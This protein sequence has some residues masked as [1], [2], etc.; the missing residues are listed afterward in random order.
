MKNF[1][2]DYLAALFVIAMFMIG[3]SPIVFAIL[4]SILLDNGY[5]MF[6]LFADVITLPLLHATICIGNKHEE[7]TW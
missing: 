2:Q 4:L 3:I 5:Y 7:E 1:L 6:I